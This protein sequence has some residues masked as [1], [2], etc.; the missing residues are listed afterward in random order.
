MTGEVVDSIDTHSVNVGSQSGA[1][2]SETKPSLAFGDG[3]TGIFE[4][5]DDNLAI[6]IAGTREMSFDSTGLSAKNAAGPAMLNEAATSTNPTL[7]PNRADEDTG[8]GWFG[9]DGVSLISGGVEAIRLKETSNHVLQTHEAHVGLTASGGSIQGG[10]PL[11][12]SYNVISTSG[13]AGDSCTLPSGFSV[14]TKITIKNDA[15]ANA[16]DVFPASGD[17]LGSGA[18]NAASLANGASITYLATVADTTWTSI[19]N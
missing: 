7:I 14:G 13:T 18:N 8:I 16:V 6:T 12:S 15:A 17:D 1:G 9:A 5:G 4:N 11:L 2:S 10:L 3:D 19:G